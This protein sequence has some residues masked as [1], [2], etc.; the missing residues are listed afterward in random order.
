MNYK[1]RGKRNTPLQEEKRQPKYGIRKLSIGVVSCFLG[2]AIYFGAAVTVH[3]EEA[4]LTAN[5]TVDANTAESLPAY[6]DIES[7]AQLTEETIEENNSNIV[8]SESHTTESDLDQASEYL[9]DEED[10]KE[11]IV[12]HDPESTVAEATEIESD[13]V[14]EA[15]SNNQN[16]S[17]TVE[18]REDK[19]IRRKREVTEYSADEAEDTSMWKPDDI[20]DNSDAVT[21]SESGTSGWTSLGWRSGTKEVFYKESTANGVGANFGWSSKP[22]GNDNY[23][24]ELIRIH[25]EQ[26]GDVIHWRVVIKGEN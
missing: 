22:G 2:C 17:D 7:N 14:V 4:T 13:A 16:I 3:A 21:I 19:P 25:A 15:N 6:D 9:L 20:E 8:L 18:S 23:A 5:S 12:I 1:Y 24:D 26:D 10:N 11:N